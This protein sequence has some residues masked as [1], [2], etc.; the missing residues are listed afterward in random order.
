[1]IHLVDCGDAAVGV[2]ASQYKSFYTVPSIKLPYLSALF[3]NRH[4][5][6]IFQIAIIAKLSV[7]QLNLPEGFFLGDFLGLIFGNLIFRELKF[8]SN[9]E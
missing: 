7:I 5:G 6:A 3:I 4:N 9:T 8:L 2:V 1:M